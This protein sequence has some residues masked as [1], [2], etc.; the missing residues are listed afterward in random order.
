MFVIFDDLS[1]SDLLYH[2]NSLFRK[3]FMMRPHFVPSFLCDLPQVFSNVKS[4]SFKNKLGTRSE[5]S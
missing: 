4:G 3:F 5:P 1:F 2:S